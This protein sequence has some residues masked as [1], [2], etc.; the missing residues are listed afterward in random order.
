MHGEDLAAERPGDPLLVIEQDVQGEVHPGGRRDRADR[1]VDRIA[2]D[3]APGGT[4]VADPPRVVELERGREAGEPRSDHLGPAAEPG[5]EVRLHEAG[6][7]P[8]VR[9]HPFPVEE[10]RDVSDHPQVDL[11]RVVAGVVVL[12]PPLCEHVVTQHRPT[13]GDGRPAV[14]AGGDEDDDVLGSDD[15][16]ERLHDRPEHRAGEVADG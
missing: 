4:R 12:D 1:V 9:G 13:L 7:D 8:Q 3:D 16:V 15:P 14:G 10:D 2:L 6:R 5:E 11:P